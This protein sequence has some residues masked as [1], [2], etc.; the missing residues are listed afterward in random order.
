MLF[1]AQ[2]VGVGLP[3][4]DCEKREVHIVLA[5]TALVLYPTALGWGDWDA[6]RSGWGSAGFV[7]GLSLLALSCFWKGLRRLPLP[8]AAALMAWSL[9]AL[10]SDN[11][12]D[13]LLD[14][15][16]ACVSIGVALKQGLGF[17]RRPV[18]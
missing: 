3:V 6:Y 13:Y 8:I 16:L 7:I 11:L 17:S 5:F 9:G 10:E 4:Q 15:W 1:I 2:R 14:P 12:W 18:S